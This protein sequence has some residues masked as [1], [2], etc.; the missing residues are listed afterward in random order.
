MRLLV[1]SFL[2]FCW[3][4]V[5]TRPFLQAVYWSSFAAE[6]STVEERKLKKYQEV[7]ARDI[8]VLDRKADQILKELTEVKELYLK[9]SREA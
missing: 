6:C 5:L 4:F 9:Y 3:I 2:R 1:A 7:Y 8:P